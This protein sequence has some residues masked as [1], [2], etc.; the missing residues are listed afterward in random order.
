M[1]GDIISAIGVAE[2]TVGLPDIAEGD[3]TCC[4]LS[5]AGFHSGVV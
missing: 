4:G 3:M 5:L 1:Y 2:S